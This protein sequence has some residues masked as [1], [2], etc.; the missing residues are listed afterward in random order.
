MIEPLPMIVIGTIIVVLLC[1]V[2]AIRFSNY[3]VRM[4]PR[5]PQEMPFISDEEHVITTHDVLRRLEQDAR[6]KNSG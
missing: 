2:V 6:G 1:T 5:V 3:Q 4:K